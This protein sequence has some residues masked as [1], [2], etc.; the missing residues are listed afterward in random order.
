MKAW[1]FLILTL[2][3]CCKSKKAEEPS[4]SFPVL[5]FIQ[6]QVAQVDTSLY[7]ITKVVT[8]DSTSDTS[9]LR[10]EDFRKA[11]Q[12]FLSL[13]DIASKKMRNGYTE[14]RTYDQ[15]LEMAV[16]TYTARDDDQPVRKE[17]VFI[18]PGNGDPD[19]V[20]KLIID[21]EDGAGAT[22]VRKNL[23]WNVGG[24][25]QVVTGTTGPDGREKMVTTRVTWK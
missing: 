16:L 5:S 20:K 7:N 3:V 18:Q 24:S 25:F 9:Y 2:L 11:A 17:Q 23:I 1:P 6:S 14:E 4:G 8:V 12:D 15:L 13:P 22:A 21:V 10:R 19:Q